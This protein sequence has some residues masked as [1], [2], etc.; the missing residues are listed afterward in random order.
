MLL[1]FG[2][3]DGSLDR[4]NLLCATLPL[5]HPPKDF[6]LGADRFGGGEAPA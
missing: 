2:M 1:L 4:H 3:G 5:L 6:F